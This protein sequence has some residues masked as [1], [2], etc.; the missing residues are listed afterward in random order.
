MVTHRHGNVSRCSR[1]FL[2]AVK[3]QP[4]YYRNY[5][6]LGKAQMALGQFHMAE[7]AL[8]KALEKAP[9]DFQPPASVEIP[10][11]LRQC[12]NKL[13]QNDSIDRDA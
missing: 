10:E 7:D 1:S 11:L 6:G 2:S 9:E 13:N 12:K 3:E 4:E 5:W 8:C